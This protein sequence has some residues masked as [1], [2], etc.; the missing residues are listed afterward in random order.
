MTK[1][2][3]AA[4]EMTVGTIVTI[5][6]LMSALVLGLI[7]TNTI[8]KGS[9][10]NIESIDEG[11]KNQ[12]SEMFAKDDLKKI[13]LYPG[14]SISIKKG[15]D[16]A[17]FAFSIRNLDTT[18][19]T[20]SYAVVASSVQT[21]CTLS[22]T[23]ANKYI[24]L[25]GTGTGIQIPAGNVMSNPIMVKFAIPENA[26]PCTVRYKL[27]ISKSGMIPPYE[28]IQIDVKIISK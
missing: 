2:K 24:S 11:V 21:G 7:L 16:D 1:N 13:V 20:F 6:L 28:F 17:G 18:M 4:M 19:G 15:G 22:L 10:E 14:T 23:E 5:V 27:T 9:K 12:I 25:G 26:P 8:F 3:R